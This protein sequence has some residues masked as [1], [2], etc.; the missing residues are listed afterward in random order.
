[1]R[2]ADGRVYD[3]EWKAGKQEGRGVY[4]YPDGELYDGEWKAG[5]REGRGVFRF[6]SGDVLSCFCKQ[7]DPVGEGVKWVADGQ[8]AWRLRDGEAVEMI[9]LEEARQTAERLG[10][11]LPSP[12]PG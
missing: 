10:L 7:D 11:P 2:F 3:G 4:R 1:M 12:L 5:E 9:S 8:Q 6:A